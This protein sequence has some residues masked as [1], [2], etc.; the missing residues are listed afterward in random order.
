MSY[1]AAILGHLTL[2]L[3]ATSVRARIEWAYFWGTRTMPVSELRQILTQGDRD[4]LDQT[5]AYL[6]ILRPT[7]AR[8][9]GG[10]GSPVL[11]YGERA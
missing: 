10:F 4:W 11:V 6:D 8:L 2:L 7:G 3:I 5:A 1:L 9:P